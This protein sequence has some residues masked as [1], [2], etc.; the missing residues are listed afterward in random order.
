MH[1][2]KFGWKQ[3]VSYALVLWG[4]A[5]A[6][7]AKTIEDKI[8]WVLG[9]DLSEEHLRQSVKATSKEF[10][11]WLPGGSLED[12]VGSLLYRLRVMNTTNEGQLFHSHMLLWVA[13]G[14][15]RVRLTAKQAAA[16]MVTDTPD[17]VLKDFHSPFAGFYIEIPPG[18]L[19]SDQGEHK[20]PITKVFWASIPVSLNSGV[21][22][23]SYYASAGSVALWQV[24][25][26]LAQFINLDGYV[27][28]PPASEFELA[29][30]A[31]ETSLDL[32]TRVLLGRLVLN[33]CAYLSEPAGYSKVSGKK[34]SHKKRG[35]VLPLVQL[36]TM[37]NEVVHDFSG[38]VKE[39]VACGKS[40]TPLRIQFVVPGH[41]KQQPYGPRSSLRRRQWIQPYWRGPEDAPIAV[42][43]HRIDEKDSVTG[44]V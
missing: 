37:T 20:V 11:K 30:L 12:K 36:Y 17:F 5:V 2:L 10:F 41:F 33:S 35:S 19:Y 18:L 26:D 21:A 3:E 16:M 13:S 27:R 22:T 7:G 14:L 15:P 39:Y 9:A 8:S 42:R 32:K 23:Y 43:S 25:K 24:Q 4:A 34:N 28:M 40:G 6:A 1:I 44:G 31:P 29:L 38:A